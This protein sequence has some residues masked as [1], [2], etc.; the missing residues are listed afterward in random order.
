MATPAP[1]PPLT[2][3]DD[4]ELRLYVSGA[5]PVSSRAIVNL[6]RFCEEHLKGRYRLEILDISDCVAKATADQIVAAPTLLKLAPA[7]VRRLI[8]DMSDTPRMLSGLSV[9]VAGP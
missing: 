7:P 3:A 9:R 5:T 1:S 2:A 6:R 4:Y 8:G